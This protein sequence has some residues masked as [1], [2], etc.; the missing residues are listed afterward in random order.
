MHKAYVMWQNDQTREWFVV[1]CLEQL[2]E[3]YAF[4]YTRGAAHARPSFKGFPK[5]LDLAKRYSSNEL[6]P[7]FAG[8][9]LPKG[10]PEYENV[11]QWLD[12]STKDAKDILL[13]GRGEGKKETDNITLHACPEQSDGFYE[14]KF[15]SHGLRYGFH[16]GSMEERLGQLKSGE[17]LLPVY[18][19]QNPA[20]RNAI[21]LR[22]GDPIQ[23][24]G[25]CPRYL[26]ADF[27]KLL[28]TPESNFQIT[29]AQVNPLAPVHFKL[30]CKARARWPKGF[31]PFASESYSPYFAYED[32]H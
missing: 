11:L 2:G 27:K 30:L 17:T 29:V 4:Y 21:L 12:L 14:I 24:M 6:P 7:L 5:M 31:I 19:V 28:D 1:G 25:Y 23:F 3:G 18:D 16:S 26:T 9:L 20:D 13:L 32:E 8:R 22:S 10:R 15:L